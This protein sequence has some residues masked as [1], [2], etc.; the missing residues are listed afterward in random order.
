M[1]EVDKVRLTDGIVLNEL[2][3]NRSE[4]LIADTFNTF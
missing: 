3:F 1:M 4:F 2:T